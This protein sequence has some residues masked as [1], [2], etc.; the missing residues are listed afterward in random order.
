MTP[1]DEER[2]VRIL[3]NNQKTLDLM[4]DKLADL[5]YRIECLER[6]R[7]NTEDEIRSLVVDVSNATDDIVGLH[8]D[9]ENLMLLDGNP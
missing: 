6:D 9:I 8:R 7:D 3:E 4:I 5:S 2:I 1:I